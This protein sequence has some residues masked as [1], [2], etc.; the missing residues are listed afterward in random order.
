MAEWEGP[1][2]FGKHLQELD[3]LVIQI[4]HV[5][6]KPFIMQAFP[7]MFQTAIF[8]YSSITLSHQNAVFPGA[9]Q[10]E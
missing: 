7:D 6:P 3:I 9:P 4:K 10:G 5:L 2:G 1:K 8:Y